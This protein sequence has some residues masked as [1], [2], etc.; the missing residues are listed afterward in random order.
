LDLRRGDGP[1]G[2]IW[3]NFAALTTTDELIAEHPEVAAGAMRAIVKAQQAL[4]ADPS[5]AGKVGERLFPP[6]EAGLIEGLIRRDAPFYDAHISQRAI[7]GLNA[8]GH[9]NGLLTSPVAYDRVVASQ[10]SSLWSP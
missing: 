5:L 6:E 9:A 2:A 8:F 1:P 4:K 3:Y 7:D 10:F